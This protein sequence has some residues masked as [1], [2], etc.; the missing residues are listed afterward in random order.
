M[1]QT[2]KTQ[3]ML[4]TKHTN[5]ISGVLIRLFMVKQSV[6]QEDGKFVEEATLIAT[7]VII[8]LNFTISQHKLIHH[9]LLL[10]NYATNNLILNKIRDIQDFSN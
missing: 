7:K 3:H 4:L 8:L 9:Y 10:I 2:T 1:K 6:F 5:K